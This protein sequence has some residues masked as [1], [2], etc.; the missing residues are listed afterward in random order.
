MVEV[1]REGKWMHYCIAVP[2]C[3]SARKVLTDTLR[4]LAEDKEMKKDRERLTALRQLAEGQS[5]RSNGR[6]CCSPEGLKTIRRAPV[7]MPTAISRER[8]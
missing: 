1:R 4:W 2:E 3:E 7:P 8:N 6:A 5:A